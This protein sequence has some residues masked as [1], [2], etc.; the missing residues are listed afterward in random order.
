MYFCKLLEIREKSEK[1]LEM[2]GNFLYNLLRRRFNVGF[3]KV[4]IS[5]W[6]EG[7]FMR[8]RILS[9]LL[10]LVMVTSLLPTAVFAEG[11]EQTA[12]SVIYVDATSGNDTQGDVG[13][14]SDSASKSL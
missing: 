13:T 6:K 3:V 11:E 2:I 4:H 1:K 14:A 7:Y 5:K 9:V 8:K 10:C 12:G